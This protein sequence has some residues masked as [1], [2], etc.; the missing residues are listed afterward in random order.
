MSFDAIIAVVGYLMWPAL[1]LLAA[2][3]P[4][5]ALLVIAGDF[6]ER[7]GAMPDASTRH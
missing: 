7:R 1:V 6:V 3:L 5:I 4:V 2:G